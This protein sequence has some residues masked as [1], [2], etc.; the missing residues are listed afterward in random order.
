[1]LEILKQNPD[2]DFQFD[3]EF[4]TKSILLELGLAGRFSLN[5]PNVPRGQQSQQL[6][7]YGEHPPRILST[8]FCILETQTR[9]KT[10]M[11][12]CACHGVK[13]PTRNLWKSQG[14][15]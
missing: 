8:S 6:V 10:G 12:F 9:R 4:E 7:S 3:D 15:S 14:N 5:P 1:M 2:K 11:L 13:F